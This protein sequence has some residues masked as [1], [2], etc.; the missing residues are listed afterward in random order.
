MSLNTGENSA[1]TSA[2]SRYHNC[3]KI[4]ICCLDFVLLYIRGMLLLSLRQENYIVLITNLNVAEFRDY[5][6]DVY[7]IIES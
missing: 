7:L 5:V 1:P 2:V 4:F 6:V 3:S